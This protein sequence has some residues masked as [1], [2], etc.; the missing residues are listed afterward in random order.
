M[1]GRRALIKE[2]IQPSFCESVLG[3]GEVGLGM[4]KREKR[5]SRNKRG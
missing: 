1:L 5:K 2:I 4:P 3:G